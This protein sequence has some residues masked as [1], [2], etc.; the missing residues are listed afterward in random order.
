MKTVFLSFAALVFVVVVLSAVAQARWRAGTA[1]EVARLEAAA[2]RES[3]GR[4]DPAALDSLPAPVARYLRAALRD[5]TP[6]VRHATIRHAGEFRAD[7]TGGAWVPLRSSEH[8]TALS[9]GFVWDARIRMAPFA[10]AWVR[11]ELIAGVAAMRARVAAVATVADVAGTPALAAGAL[12]RWLG[13]AVWFPTALLPSRF[14]RWSAVDDSTAA[15]TA[16]A[17]A[18][19][20]SLVFHFGPDSLP[21]FAETPARMRDVGG[22]GVPTPWRARLWAWQWRGGMRVPTRSEVEW[23][24]ASGPRPYWR[25]TITEAV[26][27]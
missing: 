11:D 22:V 12:H 27:E 10:D 13:E 3:P 17:G 16:T 5:G 18:A 8:F 26:Y 23:G 24:L 19:T 14:L 15:A 1:A 4:F 7:T 25:A 20:V 6:L 21:R 2:P 9:P